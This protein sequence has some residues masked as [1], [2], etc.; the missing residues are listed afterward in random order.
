[1]K[2]SPVTYKIIY[3][4]RNITKDISDHLISLSY[5]DKLQGES[6]E[7][8]LELE[9]RDALWQNAWYPQKGAVIYAEIIDAG[10]LLKCGNFTIDEIQMSGSKS[11]GDTVS[12]SAMAAGITKKIRT[13]KNTAHE[14]KTLRQLAKSVADVHALTVQ[15]NIPDIRFNRISQNH[16]SDLSFLNRISNQYG[17][18][19]SIRDK[20]LIFQQEKEL[21]GKAA[22]LSLDKTEIIDYSFTDKATETFKK[23]KVKYHNSSTA[24]TVDYTAEDNTDGLGEDEFSIKQKAENKQQAEL[25]ATGQLNKKNKSEKTV[26]VTCPGN[27]LILSGS[28]VEMTGYGVFSGVYQVTESSHNID[29][30]G[31]Y[32][33]SFE[34]KRVATVP[35]GKHIPKRKKGNHIGGSSSSIDAG[36]KNRRPYG[37]L[38]SVEDITGLR[39]A[40]FD[41]LF[42][43]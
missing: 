7:L 3:D 21:Q 11:S 17:I 30:S 38:K 41:E 2:L 15:G 5:T 25:M 34:G 40:T 10:V 35:S 19:F 29:N 27:V 8:S 12:I 24:E 28:N 20:L 6:D 32:T 14:N 23:A 26:S 16:E 22:V 33:T 42:K 36:R 4:N 18:I 39:G 31:G 13:K 9:D 43:N 1:M 37:V